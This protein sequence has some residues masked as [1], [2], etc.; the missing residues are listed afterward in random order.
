MIGVALVGAAVVVSLLLAASARFASLVSALLVAYL[1]LVANV[2]L[3]TLVLSP[4]RG[5]TRTGLAV[6]EAVL[7]VAAFLVWW[8]RGR[9]PFPLAAARPAVGAIVR[10]PLTAL[11]LAAIAALL[12]YELL[13]ALTVPPTNWDSLTYHLSRAVAWADH[14]G[15]YRIANAP[16]ERMNDFQPLAEQELLFLFVATGRGTLLALPQYLAELAILL[17]IYGTGRRLGFE[18]RATVCSAFLFAS[19]GLVVS[20]AASAQNDLIAASFPIV[21]ACLLLGRSRLEYLLAGVAVGIGVG[22]KL[23]VLMVVPVLLVLA[24]AQRRALAWAAA[25]GMIGIATIGVWGY[26]LNLVHTGGIFGETGN[27]AHLGA[28]AQASI[29]PGPLSTAVDVLYQMLDLASLSDRTINTLAIVGIAAALTAALYAVSRNH[30]WRAFGDGASVAAP[31]LASLLVIGVGAILASLSKR[32]GFPIRGPTGNL[33]SLNRNASLAVFGPVGALALLTV[34]F[35]TAAAYLRRRADMRHVALALSLPLFLVLLSRVDYNWWLPRF[36]LV[37]AALTAPVFSGLFR[38]RAAIAGYLI[39]STLVIASVIQDDPL[40]TP[41]NRF[42]TPWNLTQAQALELS[43][44]RDVGD[45][46]TAFKNLVP[47]HACIGAVLGPD[48][49]AYLLAGPSLN[50]HIVYLPVAD[51][52]ANA[53]QSSLFYVVIS[54]GVNRWAAE[55]FHTDGWTIQPLSRYWILAV[56]PHATN[57]ACYP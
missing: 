47:S 3:V 20:Q 21:A 10:D 44:Q 32:W 34:P 22:A 37:P 12:G 6:A 56:R 15:I 50:H 2:G 9:P 19:F 17:A 52:V 5:V 23:T 4:F 55:H 49:P 43:D 14:G 29:H 39:V 41:H 36:L 13:L 33:G 48:E 18:P 35:L 30:A 16:T 31:F 28:P 54:T 53:Y 27:P 45:A 7:V 42:G 38:S 46:V 51:A 25:G 57:G 11:V 24:V 40:Q 1:A 26:L 8:L